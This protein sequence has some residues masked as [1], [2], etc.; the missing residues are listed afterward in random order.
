MIP[1]M[2]EGK[3]QHEE[4]LVQGDVTQA[5][6]TLNMLFDGE[7]RGKLI[8]QVAEPELEVPGAG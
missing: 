1:W 4:T 7:N 3:L 6:E 2:Q 8:L 5:P